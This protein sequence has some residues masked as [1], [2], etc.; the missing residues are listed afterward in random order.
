MPK[1]FLIIKSDT[2]WSEFLDSQTPWSTVSVASDFLQQTNE[3][4]ES[5]SVAVKHMPQTA[6]LCSSIY[7]TNLVFFPMWLAMFAAWF[8]LVSWL[9]YS[10]ILKMEVIRSSGMPVDFNWATQHDVSEDRTLHNH[11]CENLKSYCS[12]QI[13]NWHCYILFY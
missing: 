7:K 3:N 4:Q 11:H 9:A 12:I 2:L 1:I 5:Q 6:V 8:M 13:Y 10:S